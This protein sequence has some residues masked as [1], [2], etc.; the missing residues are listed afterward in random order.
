MSFWLATLFFCIIVVAFD[1]IWSVIAQK[2]HYSYSKGAIISFLIYAL[3]GGV[4]AYQQS[5]WYGTISGLIVAGIDATVGWWLSAKIG[6]GQLP[7]LSKNTNI[8]FAILQTAV[9]VMVFGGAIGTF[10][11]VIVFAIS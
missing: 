9:T 6:P 8:P 11:A 2:K 3:A 5:I 10:G 4:A 7:N 1:G